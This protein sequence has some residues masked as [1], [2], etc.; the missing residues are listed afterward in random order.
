VMAEGDD[1]VLVSSVVGEIVAA[2][3]EAAHAA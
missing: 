3:Q 2:V 1:E